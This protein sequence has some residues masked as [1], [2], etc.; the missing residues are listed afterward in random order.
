MPHKWEYCWVAMAIDDDG[1]EAAVC[2]PRSNGDVMTVMGTD[3]ESLESSRPVMKKI[4]RQLGRP[5]T[6]IRFDQ[7]RD[8]EI[9][10]P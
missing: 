7:R 6:V 1:D 2:W 5:V 10:E 3:E 4:A 8:L 9:V